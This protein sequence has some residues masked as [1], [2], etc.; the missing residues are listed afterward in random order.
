MVWGWGAVVAKTLASQLQVGEEGP[1][2]PRGGPAL[3]APS[4]GGAAGA[5]AGSGDGAV[6]GSGG[7]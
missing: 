1:K 4:P 6:L 7:R 2:S 3:G 5:T